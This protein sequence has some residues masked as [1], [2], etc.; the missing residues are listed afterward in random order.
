MDYESSDDEGVLDLCKELGIRIPPKKKNNNNTTRD[1]LENIDINNLPVV[2]IPDNTYVSSEVSVHELFEFH[3]NVMMVQ[4]TAHSPMLPSNEE[5]IDINFAQTSVTD[6]TLMEES[7]DLAEPMASPLPL[8]DEVEQYGDLNSGR[9][10]CSKGCS[11]NKNWTKNN[12]KKLRM[13]VKEYLGYRR[14]SNGS[15]FR[16]LHD[17]IRPARIIGPRCTT[18]F[19]KKSQLSARNTIP[20]EEQNTLF[21]NYWNNMTREQRKQYVVSNVQVCPKKQVKCKSSSSRRGETKEYF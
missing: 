4:T 11:V 5:P 1:N 17:T 7:T 15:K 2:I 9:K 14:D 13:E 19:C 3:N 21:S 18:E 12:N 8:S 16:V 20:E 6:P 10:R